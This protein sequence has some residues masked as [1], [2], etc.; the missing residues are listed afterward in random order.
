[1]LL[2]GRIRAGGLATVGLVGA[3][4][5]SPGG[6]FAEDTTDPQGQKEATPA[7]KP[8]QFEPVKGTSAKKDKTTGEI[9][10]K[11][12]S[13]HGGPHYEVY[14]NKREYDKGNRDRQV[15]ADGSAGRQY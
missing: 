13:G 9:W 7:T 1:V 10:A 3:Y 11:D 15:W 6:K 5:V 2:G 8:D 12:K 14:K 4:L